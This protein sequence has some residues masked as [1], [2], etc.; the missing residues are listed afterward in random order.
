MPI[1]HMLPLTRAAHS[2]FGTGVKNIGSYKLDKPMVVGEFSAGSTNGKRS[3]QSLYQSALQKGFAGAWDWSLLGGDK[4]DDAATAAQGMAAL[5]SDPSVKVN[6]N[7]GKAVTPVDD[8]CSCSDK[9]PPPGSY[10]CEKQAGWGK[11]GLS[12]M[13]GFCCRSCHACKGCQ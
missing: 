7:G 8:S 5:A 12:F 9:A 11:C 13:K 6:I 2:P 10:S 3:I 4:N 1:D